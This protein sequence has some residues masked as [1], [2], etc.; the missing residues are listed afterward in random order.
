MSVSADVIAVTS[1][2]LEARIALGPGVSVICNHASRLVA[3][4][5]AAIE[6]GAAGIIS[7]GIAGGLAPNLVAG[8]WVIGSGVRT[9]HEC[10]PADQRW[11]RRLLDALP[12]AVHAEIAGADGPVAHA[13]EKRR[14]HEL[15]GAV[16][17]DMESHI[18]GRIAAAHK[19]P[20]A[21]CRT[22]IDAAHRDL[23]P[24]ALVGLR[25]DGTPDVLAV[26][27]S[28]ARRPSQIAALRRTGLDAWIARQALRHGRRLL[29][30]GFGCPYLREQPSDVT[31]QA[32]LVVQADLAVQ[33]DLLGAPH[34]RSARS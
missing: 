32:D 25:H 4:L 2:S 3:T 17:V 27:R 29:G 11:A 21:I 1:L 23:P 18:A 5:E 30:A 7:F 33:A 6:H 26:S 22:V 14:L 19:I 10:H 9:E 28:V 16:A 34:L 24:A 31:V 15:M 13:S 20:F 12:G 8:D